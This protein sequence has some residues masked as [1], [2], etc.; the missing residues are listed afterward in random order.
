VIEFGTLADL[1]AHLAK[2]TV[3][4]LTHT[5]DGIAAAAQLLEREAKAE[6]G[7]YQPAAGPFASWPELADA[8]K[9]DR[10]AQGYTENDPLLRD[11][12]LRDSIKREVEDWE[13][14][15]GSEDPVMLYQELGTE[16]IP[17]RPVLGTALW[18][19]I[20]KVQKLV[21]FAAVSGFVGGDRIDPSVGYDLGLTE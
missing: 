9:A 12:T 6:F 3:G 13:A 20:D 15:V 11:G 5:R 14:I 2:E 19:N 1:A 8:T 18:L 21:G 7:H 10:V 16:R 17:P 4:G